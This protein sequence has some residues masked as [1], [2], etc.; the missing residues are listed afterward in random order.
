MASAS[1]ANLGDGRGVLVI[2]QQVAEQ[3]I[4]VGG[5]FNAGAILGV[6]ADEVVHA[7]T[8]VADLGQ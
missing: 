5:E 1:E 6:V 3:L 4:T 8:A 2:V 7:V